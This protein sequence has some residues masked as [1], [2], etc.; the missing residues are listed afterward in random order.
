VYENSSAQPA[1]RRPAAVTAA[2]YLL[3]GVAVLVLATAVLALPYAGKVVDAARQTFGNVKNGDAVIS[4]E[5]ASAYGTPIAYIIVAIGLADV[6][7]RR[8]RCT[9]LREWHGHRAGR[10]GRR[11]EQHQRRPRAAQCAGTVPASG[12][13]TLA[14]LAQRAD[15]DAGRTGAARTDRGDHSARTA[16]LAPILRSRPGSVRRPWASAVPGRQR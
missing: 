3:F 10:L 6:G 16:G 5:Q 9:V 12:G 7:R 11:S 2:G 1:D 15:H 14:V 4:V 13:C 8:H